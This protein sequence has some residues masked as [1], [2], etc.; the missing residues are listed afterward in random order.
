MDRSWR[1]RQNSV[2]PSPYK[3][4]GMDQCKAL[5]GWRS[6]CLKNSKFI[7]LLLQ[8]WWCMQTL[9]HNT[10]KDAWP[11]QWPNHAGWPKQPK[12]SVLP[13]CQLV[14]CTQG[15]QRIGGGGRWG[16]EICSTV[17]HTDLLMP[18]GSWPWS[19]DRCPLPTTRHS[20][21]SKGKAAG[22]QGCVKQGGDRPSCLTAGW[23]Q[24][25]GPCLDGSSRTAAEEDREEWKGC[26]DS[27]SW[28]WNHGTW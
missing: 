8:N 17:N 14:G 24:S 2:C 15:G 18:H 13:L 7:A 1:P 28:L 16:P 5:G 6:G 21:H 10:F 20:E 12:H 9:Q 4:S 27:P 3:G 26:G 19:C 25:F 22:L 11:E 23:D